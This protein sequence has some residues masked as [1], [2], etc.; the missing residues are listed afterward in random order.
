LLGAAEGL[1]GIDDPLLTGEA[2]GKDAQRLGIEPRV[3]EGTGL[4][5]KAPAS[6][7]SMSPWRNLPR[8]RGER[9]STGKR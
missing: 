2:A 3:F 7:R 5:L 4:D 1:F 8:K 6:K 9:A